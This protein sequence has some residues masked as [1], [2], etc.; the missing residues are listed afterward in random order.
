MKTKHSK[1][2]TRTRAGR[3]ASLRSGTFVRRPTLHTRAVAA[4]QAITRAAIACGEM[5]DVDEEYLLDLD[6]T[7]ADIVL[8]LCGR[9]HSAN[10]VKAIERAQKRAHTKELLIRSSPNNVLGS[11]AGHESP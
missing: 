4:V 5:G 3:T 8:T 10:L 2:K 9:G 7:K 11:S 6:A 1:T